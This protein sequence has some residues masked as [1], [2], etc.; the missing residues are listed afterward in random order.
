MSPNL[1]KGP[2]FH[3]FETPSVSYDTAWATFPLSTMKRLALAIAILVSA[4]SKISAQEGSPGKVFSLQGGATVIRSG[5]SVKVSEGMALRGGDEIAVASPGRVALELSDGSYIRLASGTTMKFPEKEREV[6]LLQG[7]LHFFSHTERHPTVVTEHVTAAIR[8]TEFWLSTSSRETTINML[9]GSVQGSSPG[10]VAA[11]GA[12]QGARFKKQGAPEVFALLQSDRNVQWSAFIP[13][14]EDASDLRIPPGSPE[15]RALSLFN[16]GRSTEALALLPS[17]STRCSTGAVLR[18]RILVASGDIAGGE[19]ILEGCIL[20]EANSPQG[21]AAASTLALVKLTEGDIGGADRLS[22]MAITSSPLSASSKL[23][24]SLTLQS[25]GDLEGALSVLEGAGSSDPNLEA[26]RAEVLFMFGR[27]PEARAALESISNRSWYAESIYGFVLMGDRDFQGAAVA[28]KNAASAE[29]GAGLPQVGLGLIAVNEGDLTGGRTHFE[30]ATVLEP[31]RSL[32]RSYLAKSYFEQDTYDPAEPEYDRAVELDPNDPTPHLY[33][34]FMRLAQ[35]KPIEA[36]HDIEAARDLSEKRSVYRSKFLLDED[37][38]IQSASL[39]R[40]YRDLGFEQRGKI[41]AIRAIYS[42]YENSSAHRLLSETQD[43]VFGAASSLSERRIADLFSPLSINVVDSI[44]SSVSLNEYSSLFERDGWRTGV[45]AGFRS[46][47]DQ[48]SA[49]VISANKSGNVVTGITAS[50]VVTDGAFHDPS[51]HDGRVGVSFQGQPDWANRWM[52]EGSGD[53]FDSNQ[54][55]DGE[56][57]G[58]GTVVGSLLHRF[59]PDTTGVVLSSFRRGRERFHRPVSDSDVFYTTTDGVLNDL[60]GATFDQ[61]LKQFETRV[62]NEAQLI[63]KSGP[64]TSILTGRYQYFNL[65][66]YDSSTLVQDEIGFLDEYGIGFDSSRGTNV[67]SSGVSYLGALQIGES[68]TVNV[69]GDYS[70]VQFASAQEEPFFPGR[71][72]NS[73]LTPKA[74]LV[75]QPDPRVLVRVGYGQNLGK[76][77]INAPLSIEPTMVGGITQR[78]NDVRPGTISENFGSGVDLQPIESLYIGGEWT[79]R[80]IDE[81]R[82]DGVY[83]ASFDPSSGELTLDSIYQDRLD[84]GLQQDFASAY[85]YGVVSK[86]FVLGSDY[87]FA[88]SATGFPDNYTLT[89]H[90]SRTFARYFFTNMFFLQ[91]GAAFRY[92]ERLN[93]PF[94]SGSESSCGWILDAALGYRLP[95]RQGFI[96]AGLANILGKDFDL[97][98]TNYFNDIVVNEP[99]FELA[100]KINF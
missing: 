67:S 74:G 83:S 22:K 29:P 24:R 80:W 50:G 13:F 28:F 63:D 41:E 16:D 62:A 96:T 75:F 10:G 93:S 65:D 33:R 12:G 49:G 32:Y 40:V 59:S 90:F 46:E 48:Y 95:T 25:Q 100:A 39:S 86:Q 36:L 97:D 58:R 44:G 3:W 92:Q 66:G 84:T 30:R 31:S 70:N 23:A 64:L 81:P 78:F 61:Q 43:S 52:L 56:T 6:G 85:L 7:T 42:D 9:S 60:Y 55:E 34:S 17:L 8:G 20:S 89:D 35:N 15:A 76:S 38:A 91:T 1:P 73:K 54:R 5:A 99:V 14:A 4:S 69:G 82:S 53:F 11:L 94:T 26:R 51:S 2:E 57:V 45:S 68:L 21:A 79:R 37:S 71:E 98:Q 47:S 72:S 77:S 87:K 27:V 88:K 18:G 19:G